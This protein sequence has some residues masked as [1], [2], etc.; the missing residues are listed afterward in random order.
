MGI[1]VMSKHPWRRLSCV[2]GT[3]FSLIFG[4]LVSCHPSRPVAESFPASLSDLK[5]NE[6]KKGFSQVLWVETDATTWFL[7][8]PQN[9]VHRQADPCGWWG[10]DVAIE[11]EFEAGNLLAVRTGEDGD[12]PIRFTN[13]TLTSRER[14][15]ATYSK[16][17]RLR[18]SQDH[19]FLDGGYAMTCNQPTES[20][21]D[22][23]EQWLAVPSGNYEATVYAIDWTKEPGA[24]DQ[25]GNATEKALS[26]Y[27]VVLKPIADLKAIVPPKSVPNLHPDDPSDNSNVA[28]NTHIKHHFCAERVASLTKPIEVAWAVANLRHLSQ[29]TQH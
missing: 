10:Y 19:L 20:S 2:A 11:K 9:L 12:F 21:E 14:T 27:V 4:L 13:Q 1:V 17:F 15:Y 8:H 7:F 24:V 3:A 6:L 22:F 5:R 28:Q 18:V 25:R 23:P 16:K 29:A 26:S